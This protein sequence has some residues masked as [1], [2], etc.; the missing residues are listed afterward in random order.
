MSGMVLAAWLVSS[1]RPYPTLAPPAIA[2]KPGAAEG[3]EDFEDAGQAALPRATALEAGF[4]GGQRQRGGGCGHRLADGAVSWTLE[5]VVRP[6]DGE[7]KSMFSS[8]SIVWGSIAEVRTPIS[9]PRRFSKKS[10]NA[11][12]GLIL[13]SFYLTE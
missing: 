9:R 7:T 8:K 6:A 13:L 3:F 10:A 2:L 5:V 4:D 12:C 1:T 11:T